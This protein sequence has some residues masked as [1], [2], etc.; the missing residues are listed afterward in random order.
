MSMASEGAE[1]PP[2][3]IGLVPKRILLIEDDPDSRAELCH[4]L[5]DEGYTVIPAAD[6]RSGLRLA[7]SERPDLII[8]DL[9]LPD[10]HGFDLIAALRGLPETSKLP[11]VALSGFSAR[12]TEARATELGFTTCVSKPPKV[13]ELCDLV[14]S[15]LAT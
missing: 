12:L 10:T 13:S 14:R 6:G 5:E 8:Q 2:P 1:R 7:R 4:L 15:L 9:L 11:I 3:G